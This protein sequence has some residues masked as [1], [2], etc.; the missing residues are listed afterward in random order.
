MLP[1]FNTKTKHVDNVQDSID[2]GN[3]IHRVL[4]L[5]QITQ[6]TPPKSWEFLFGTPFNADLY[7]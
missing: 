5:E 7:H 6:F 3:Y 4:E 2:F 1:L